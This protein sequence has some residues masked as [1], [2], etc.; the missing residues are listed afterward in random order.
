MPKTPMDVV[1][2]PFAVEP[3]TGVM[4]P[5][6]IF[7][8]ALF[9]Q[10]IT[11]HYTNKGAAALHNV[12]IYLEGISDPAIVVVPQTYSFATVPAGATV[13]VAWLG[14]FE[15]ATPG[16]RNVSFIAKADTL[17]LQRSIKQI[18][19]TKTT[20]DPATGTFTCTAPE[21]SLRMKFHQVIDPPAKGWQDCKDQERRSK[22]PWLATRVTMEVFPNPSYSGQFGDIPFQDPWWKILAIIVAIIAAIVAIVAAATGHGAAGFGASG[23][24]DESSGTVD[25]C[26]PDPSATKDTTGADTVAGVASIIAT[27][28]LAVALSD[29][30]DPWRRGQEAT[31]PGAGEMTLAETVRAAIDYPEAP[32]AG[33]PYAVEVRWTYIRTTDVAAYE[34]SVEETNN[35][36]HLLD[37]LEVDA[38]AQIVHFSPPFIIRARPYKDGTTRYRGDQLY[39]YALVVSPTKRGFRVPLTDDGIG[40]DAA[41]NDGEYTGVLDLRVAY[42]QLLSA[43]EPFAGIWLV[44]VFAQDTND[45]L[46]GMEPT[47]AATHIGGMMV[48]SAITLTLDGTLPCPLK[49]DAVVNVVA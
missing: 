33:V 18:F 41:A 36:E 17:D 40:A 29:A 8:A 49:A 3:V 12:T 30:K 11:C 28:A 19:V 6:G 20:F 43:D 21:G 5:D 1:K 25:C 16:K 23:T 34:H 31:V 38:P 7:D 2:R 47:D 15:F 10:R 37:H 39:V 27:G 24:F 46:P 13:Q 26:S 45:A 44:Y 32:N 14:N 4:L 35:N 9:Q 48:A 22:G 42:K